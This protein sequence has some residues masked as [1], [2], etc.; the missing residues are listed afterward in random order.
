M[1]ISCNQT[2]CS[3]TVMSHVPKPSMRLLD[4]LDNT[5]LD[6][7][8]TSSVASDS[9]SDSSRSSLSLSEDICGESLTWQA[10]KSHGQAENSSSSD[11][12]PAWK[13]HKTVNTDPINSNASRLRVRKT[14]GPGK[15]KQ[16]CR[17]VTV[18]WNHEYCLF[19]HVCILQLFLTHQNILSH[20]ISQ[21]SCL[22]KWQNPKPNKV[23]PRVISSDLMK[24]VNGTPSKLRL[25]PRST[26][27]SSLQPLA[28]ITTVFSLLFHITCLN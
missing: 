20:T 10:S 7:C 5:V 17:L 3:V 22:H 12:E 27:Y 15:K 1:H 28:M 21:Y 14:H 13:C 16:N 9:K 11:E 19:S 6:D 8:S 18:D 24:I 25:W 23:I 2:T 26:W 4:I